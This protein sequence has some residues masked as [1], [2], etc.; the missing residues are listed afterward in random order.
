MSKDKVYSFLF[1]FNSHQTIS[2]DMKQSIS[3]MFSGKYLLHRQQINEEA[4]DDGKI[5]FNFGTYTNKKIFTHVKK[6]FSRNKESKG[7]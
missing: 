3:F 6:S 4:N 2:F 7:V 5:L 1:Q